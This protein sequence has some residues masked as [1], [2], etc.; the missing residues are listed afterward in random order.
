VTFWAFSDL[1]NRL[2]YIADKGLVHAN[3]QLF[4]VSELSYNRPK[5]SDAYLEKL[6][7]YWV[8]RYSAYP[9]ML[10]NAQECDKDMYHGRLNAAG[11]DENP[12]FD[13]TTNPWKLVPNYIF[14]YNPD[15]HPQT[16]HQ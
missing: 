16:A 11:Q 7:K 6:C 5:Y 1:D 2:K 15:K 10:T 14:K 4:F 8:A 3:A 13:S 9:V 12:Y